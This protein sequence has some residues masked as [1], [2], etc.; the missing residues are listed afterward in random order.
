MLKVRVL[1]L[2]LESVR[3][4]KAFHA[5]VIWQGLGPAA[6]LT[7]TSS[8]GLEAP[9]GRTWLNVIVIVV[10]TIIASFGEIRFVLSG[11]MFQMGGLFFEAY[12]L[13]L[14]QRLLSSEESKM[15]PLVSLYYYSPVCAFMIFVLAL[16]TELASLTVQ[17]LH[18][19]G[20]WTLGA[21]AATAF[22]L[23]ASSVL[24]VGTRHN[25]SQ[26]TLA[27]PRSQIG[28]TSSLVLTLCGVL[29]NI[30]I[31][32][33]SVL[34]WKTVVTPTQVAGYTVAT[35]GLL[36]YSFGADNIHSF[37]HDHVFEKVHRDKNPIARRRWTHRVIAGMLLATIVLA[38][39]IGGVLAGYR[40]EMDPRVYWYSM[41]RLT[42]SKSFSW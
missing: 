35:I 12:R 24:L 25:L 42:G 4:W 18:Q 15:D 10:G 23:N 41:S 22:L 30:I 20:L 27:Y 33:A 19:V 3:D 26:M 2:I 1:A 8:L 13:A 11:F 39:A 17:D 14:I 36:Y 16:F 28:K 6:I 38:G 40:V 29:K 5:N 37:I 34:I 7:A 9:T 21:N 31:V 32:F